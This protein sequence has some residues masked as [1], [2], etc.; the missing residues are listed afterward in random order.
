MNASLVSTT[1]ALGRDRQR[2]A[3]ITAV[4]ARHG[5]DGVLAEIG[6]GQLFPG[7]PA[8]A[9][10]ETL[11]TAP[12][13]LRRAAEALGPTFVKLG[14]ILSTRGDLLLAEWTQ[15]LERLQDHVPARPWAEVRAQVHEDLG[16]D[17][18]AVFATFDETPLAAG[19]IAQVHRARLSDGTDV[20]VKI[21]RPGLREVVGADMRLLG[22]AVGLAEARWPEIAR[23]RP[24][25]ILGN[26]SAAMAEELDFHAEARNAA[27]CRENLTGFP[28]VT[29][30]AV[31][32]TF[33]TERLLVQDFIDG[34]VPTDAASIVA[35]GLD[36]P[37]LARNGA[38]AFLH[39][40]LSDGVFHADPHPGNMR[41]LP[42][43]R[44]AFLD[45][46][47]V[48]RI[49]ARRRM[50]LLTLV[51]SIVNTA[52][53][54]VANLLVD[55]SSDPGDLDMGRLEAMADAYVARH[56]TPPLRLGDA[57][58]DFMALARDNRLALPS[59]LALL[60]KAL[61]TAD[62]V[63]RR[64]DP[65]FDAVAIARPIVEKELRDRVSPDAVLRD[66][67]AAASQAAS[68]LSDLPSAL[69][70]TMQRL[71]HGRL[72]A[73]VRLDGVDKLGDDIRWAARRIGVAIVTAAFALGLAPSLMAIGPSLLGV[74]LAVLIGLCVIA[75]GLAWLV[76][77][78]GKR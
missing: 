68:L 43:N 40:V 6:L 7:R 32:E 74:P 31:Y 59:D 28:F 49:G 48:G 38:A 9:D 16:T 45:F 22:I 54:G 70:L 64:L 5:L 25:E 60:F 66:V 78:G 62:G 24:K 47:M 12:A 20:V 61:I 72:S 27:A 75:A 63:M 36:G 57:I 50:Q 13:R 39:M 30:P 46:G 41:A 67:R 56:G 3:E 69:R 18:G 76:L 71:R 26:L 55:W 14:Q 34:I 52:P 15:E 73:D 65:D 77:P 33:T 58:L 10:D 11:R 4:L 23:Y 42:G 44:V 29:I 53:G 2:L 21:R 1:L 8:R 35:A 17:P 37:A 19:S 51:D